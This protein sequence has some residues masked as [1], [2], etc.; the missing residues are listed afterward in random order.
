[1]YLERRRLE[2]DFVA[3]NHTIRHL[4]IDPDSILHDVAWEYLSE[5][6]YL[7]WQERTAVTLNDVPIGAAFAAHPAHH[8]LLS[9]REKAEMAAIMAQPNFVGVS[10]PS[11]WFEAFPANN[12]RFAAEHLLSPAEYIKWLNGRAATSADF[13]RVF[14]N[15]YVE[16]V[17]VKTLDSEEYL[18]WKLTVGPN[19]LRRANLSWL[20]V[21]LR[22]SAATIAQR[23]LP[24]PEIEIWNEMQN[25]TILWQHFGTSPAAANFAKSVLSA[26]E[27]SQWL[28]VADTS[29]M[30]LNWHAFRHDRSIAQERV[31]QGI[32]GTG[33][34][35]HLAWRTNR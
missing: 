22:P 28:S 29:N 26:N 24:N 5:V 31:V 1:M 19:P 16:N 32:F 11:V 33:S 3:Q 34:A 14:T 9:T 20:M 4:D 12:R 2:R 18:A 30:P 6:E 25:Q 8:K 15:E 35:E 7:L 17:A 10:M 21:P 13:P 23:L 27:Y